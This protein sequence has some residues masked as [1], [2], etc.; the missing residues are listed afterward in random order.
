VPEL[1][2][3]LAG[4]AAPSAQQFVTAYHNLVYAMESE[5]IPDP[6]EVARRAEACRAAL[7]V[8]TA[9][10]PLRWGD[11][12]VETFD[13]TALDL[14]AVVELALKARAS[15][16][17]QPDSFVIQG[18]P[19]PPEADWEQ[20]CHVLFALAAARQALIDADAAAQMGKVSATGQAQTTFSLPDEVRR[21]DFLRSAAG[22]LRLGP[23]PAW[24]AVF[25]TEA[26]RGADR[27][28]PQRHLDSEECWSQLAALH[29]L[30]EAAARRMPTDPR[31][32]EPRP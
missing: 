23:W 32:G 26:Q 25:E 2:A 3:R 12:Y 19:F 15:N 4:N 22:T 18:T 17:S 20:A 27:A 13:F 21:A 9:E 14:L 11:G 24:S 8:A 16:P 1:V 10:P 7:N 6:A 5:W 30:L 31:L 29:R 28:F